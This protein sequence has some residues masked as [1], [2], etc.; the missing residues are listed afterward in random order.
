MKTNYLLSQ[1]DDQ[2]TIT[3]DNGTRVTFQTDNTKQVT[4]EVHEIGTVLAELGDAEM[5]YTVGHDRLRDLPVY[6][7]D[8]VHHVG[9]LDISRKQPDSHEGCH[10]SIS[11]HPDAW[12]RIHTTHNTL[13]TL[14]K[15]GGRFIDAHQLTDEQRSGIKRWAIAQGL[16]EMRTIYWLQQ[17]DEDRNFYYR[18]FLTEKEA[19]S[20]CYNEDEYDDI[21]EVEGFILTDALRDRM[22]LTLS[23]ANFIN[24]FD[25]VL[26][27]FGEDKTDFDGVFWT[28][29]LDPHGYS[30][31]RGALFNDKFATFTVTTETG[32][33][34]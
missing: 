3:L 1:T 16:I 28:D 23:A 12:R 5:T 32:E 21:G 22:H 10:L 11:T 29:M 15:T 17:E 26:L 30:A 7:L 13:Q 8:T 2:L 20:E 34:A 19:E 6:Q 9:T 27:A 31:P 14:T 18:L 24:N 4:L 25:Y 33:H